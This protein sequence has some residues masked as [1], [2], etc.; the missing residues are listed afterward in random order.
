[1]LPEKFNFTSLSKTGLCL[2]QGRFRPFALKAQTYA[3]PRYCLN[4]VIV[5]SGELN[6]GNNG[7]PVIGFKRPEYF[8]AILI[9]EA[10]VILVVCGFTV[11]Q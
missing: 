7:E 10:G 11:D 6:I 8:G 1:M 3:Q 4:I 2:Y 9:I 5:I